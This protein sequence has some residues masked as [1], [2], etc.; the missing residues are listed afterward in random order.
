MGRARCALVIG[1]L[2]GCE[3]STP[4]PTPPDSSVPDASPDVSPDA[5]Q[6]DAAPDAA[7]DDVG[8]DAVGDLPQILPPR[9][10][11]VP[12]P[13]AG[14]PV[15]ALG[16]LPAAVSTREGR[17]MTHDNCTQCH[18]AATGVL[19]D[20]MGR[21][22]SPTAL[23]RT[24]IKAVAARDPYWLA[25]VAEELEATPPARA[26]IENACTI[27]HAPAGN[28]GSTDAMSALHYDDITRGTTANANLARD[29]VT[30][31]ACH[32]TTAE[33]L[34]TPQS[35]T[36]GFVIGTDRRTYGP[37]ANPV[38][39]AEMNAVNYT[40]TQGAHMTRSSFCATCHTVI[41]RPL[42]AAGEV[43]GPEFPEQTCYL[44]W[45]NSAFRAEAPAAES[46]TEC[47]GCHMPTRDAEGNA[48]SAVLSTRPPMNLSPRTPIGRHVFQGANGYLL[49]VLAAENEWLGGTPTRAELT[50]A[51]D[52]AD[53]MLRRGATLTVETA[54]RAGDALTFNVRVTN[55]AGHRFPTGYPS[56]RAWLHIRVIDDAGVV[57]FESGRTDANGRLVD[58]AGNPLEP[59]RD[60]LRPHLNDVT[61]DTQVQ[62][63][64]T[65]LGD[66]N[67][68]VTHLPL[69]AARFLKDNRILPRGW[70]ATHADAALTS[71]TGVTGD[72]DFRGGEDVTHFSLNTAGWVPARVEAELLF[73]SI[74]P[75]AALAAGV[76]S[77]PA[78]ARF[79]QMVT[80][81][82]PVP[83]RVTGAMANV[84]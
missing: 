75:D 83:R 12:E 35:F 64:E 25:V 70:S 9:D 52:I 6:N 22:V 54:R 47:Q 63:Y 41:T 65:V 27:C 53:A 1:F 74:S 13:D 66:V 61:N 79:R 68:N 58:G 38:T 29:G 7:P 37:H 62:V 49:S 18:A 55:T 48:I 36:G 21:D 46:A 4:T 57:R 17:F 20:A 50:A 34:G 80:D 10:V 71:P 31:T 42:N 19:R 77:N 33:R 84:R 14:P 32:Q 11:T 78:G 2:L 8:R 3:S 39:M 60:I 59:T 56:R 5:V 24:S 45:R 69:R 82:P 44:E 30:C 51:A 28:V 67:G 81:H 26:A 76:R 23:W 15:D 40:P 43:V 16:P 73:Q 72:T